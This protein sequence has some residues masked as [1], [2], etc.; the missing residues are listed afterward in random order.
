[1]YCICLYV[2]EFNYLPLLYDIVTVNSRINLSMYTKYISLLFDT[3]QLR[4]T[5]YYF[6]FEFINNILNYLKHICN[7]KPRYIYCTC[8][9][10]FQYRHLL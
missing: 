8:I 4:K 7:N 9:L 2:L 6:I 1:M 3:F 5:L 10:I